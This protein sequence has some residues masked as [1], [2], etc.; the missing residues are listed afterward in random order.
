MTELVQDKLRDIRGPCNVVIQMYDN[1]FYLAQPEEGGLIPAVRESVSDK[2]HVHGDSVFVPKE[3]Q[4]STFILSKPIL[5]AAA[6]HQIILASPLPRYLHESC[7]EDANH[8]SNLGEEDYKPRLEEAIT[9]CRKNLKDFAF[10]HGLRNMRVVCPWTHVTRIV[11]DVWADPVHLNRVGFDAVASLLIKTAE[12]TVGMELGGSKSKGGGGGGGDGSG[13]EQQGFL[14]HGTAGGGHRGG[15][16]RGHY[17]GGGMSGRGVSGG[18]GHR[19]GHKS[20]GGW[21]GA[22]RF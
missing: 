10:R 4:Y 1:S 2:Y 9:S 13:G 11:E 16:G 20:G 17:S 6:M 14:G 7:C 21:S 19:G 3:L 12:Q 15:R 8:V 18:R 5:E 22:S